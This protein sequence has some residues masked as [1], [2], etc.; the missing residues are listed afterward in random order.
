VT[1]ISY[2]Q[3][4]EDVMLW[5]ALKHVSKGFY[6]D[7]GAWSPDFDSVTR[8]FYEAGWSGINIEPNPVFHLQLNN[9]RERDI[10]LLLAVGL[11][12]GSIAINFVG[13]TGLSTA[14]DKFALI[15]Q[16]AGWDI[17]KQEVPLLTLET[18]SKKYVPLG[19]D[20]H[21][22]KIDIEGMEEAALLGNDWINCRPW[23][24]LIEATL[25]LTQIDS[26]EGWELIIINTGYLFAYADGL[27]R[28]YVAQEHEELLSSFR[29]PPNVFD[30]FIKADYHE[31]ILRVQQTEEYWQSQ[32]NQ[33][34][35]ELERRTSDLGAA[36]ANTR[37]EL[38]NSQNRITALLNSSSWKMTLPFRYFKEKIILLSTALK[39]FSKKPN[40]ISPR[41]IFLDVSTIV[42]SDARSGI[43]RV[44]RNLSSELISAP[45]KDSIVL[46]IYIDDGQYFYADYNP[47]T[48]KFST[49]D[50]KA[51]AINFGK[52]DIYICLDLNMHLI[53]KIKPMH[54]KMLQAN[55]K[56]FFTVYDILPA[57]NPSWWPPGIHP[58]FCEWI[59]YITKVGDGLIC[60]S[61]AVVND[62]R[63]WLTL[64]N[65]NLERQ[66]LCIESFHLGANI[67]GQ[68]NSEEIISEHELDIIKKIEGDISFLMVGTIEPRKGHAQVLGAIDH[69]LRKGAPVKLVIVG[70]FGWMTE[71]VASRI[72]FHEKLN[73][74]IFWLDD[75]QDDFLK[76]IYQTCTCLVAGSQGEGFGL[77]LIEAAMYGMPIIARD[78]PVFKEIAEENAYYFKSGD[79]EGLA[80]E[81][82]QW[83]KLFKLNIHPTS[84]GMRWQ[85]WHQSAKQFMDAVN[86]SLEAGN[87]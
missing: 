68:D 61:N 19:Q 1:F 21:F 23:I 71:E 75:V 81:L 41:N 87:K 62:L 52:D 2:A 30:D 49:P 66:N 64:K 80:I 44:V 40:L 4:F 72:K 78:I 50:G 53:A 76:K 79:A 58:M 15:H 39:F 59:A 73:I 20:I 63:S 27:N 45:P 70:K 25:P 77:P 46:P 22:L 24:I 85:T 37:E 43:Q 11:Q 35:Q 83:L 86:A 47:V 6:I 54:K 74:N 34:T 10:N 67:E 60:I 29:Y 56:M 82:A 69:L 55:V 36:L 28:F 26:F 18:I 13:E 12:N 3:N 16:E 31:A 7:L 65:L 32:A 42:G 48:Y 57:M 5:R 17:N 33:I 38:S 8:A 51:S 14:L 84:R 9:R